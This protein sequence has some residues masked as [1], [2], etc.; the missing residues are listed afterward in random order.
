VLV[1]EETMRA[2]EPLPQ[3]PHCGVIA[4]PNILMFGDWNW[5]GERSETQ[6][7][8]LNVWLKNLD[9]EKV[10]VVECGAGQHIPTVRHFTE[11]LQRRGATLVR[12]NPREADGPH[13]TISLETGASAGLQAI[14]EAM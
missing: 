2:L 1:D 7:Q 12:I 5:I 11:N 9:T 13:G 8:R 6:M 14:G 3:C 4:R 10:V